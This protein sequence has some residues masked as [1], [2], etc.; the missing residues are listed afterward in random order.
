MI[1]NRVASLVYRTILVTFS[2]VGIFMCSKILEGTFNTELFVYYTYLSNILCFIVML[3]VL[4]YN[5]KKVSQGELEGYNEYI[6]KIKGATTM[7]IL[8]TGVVYHI[9]LGDPTDPSF[10]NI[11]NLIVHYIVPF[12][13]VLD[14]I[15]FDKKKI[16]NLIDPLIWTVIPL[17]Y[18]VYALI[19]G[20]IVGPTHK[21]QYCYFFIDVNE[22]GYGGVAIWCLILLVAFL[23]V[24]YLMWLVDKVVKKDDKIKLDFTKDKDISN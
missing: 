6:I 3:L 10:F 19:R 12:M 9:L 8:V 15:L 20:A 24:G 1:N 23:A 5:V 13:F 14:W 18:L 22:L 7:A 4:I 21:L 17:T 11:D 2:F 16:F